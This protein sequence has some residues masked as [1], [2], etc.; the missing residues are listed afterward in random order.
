MTSHRSARRCFT[1]ASRSG[2]DSIDRISAV[3]RVSSCPRR[4][5]WVAWAR[6]I[7]RALHQKTDRDIRHIALDTSSRTSVTLIQVLC[8]HHF[9][10]T[11]SFV[12]H[13]P[14]LALMTTA[15]D[16]GLLIGDPA[17]DAT[18]MR[19][20]CGKIDLGEVWTEMTGLPFIYAAWTG[21]PA[22]IDDGV[23][24][25]L[26]QAQAEGRGKRSDRRGVRGG[27]CESRRAGRH[28]P[29]G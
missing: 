15:C 20:G 26:Q 5:H 24:R 25:A 8:R 2:A 10:I 11:P 28:L 19:S 4:R 1:R 9:H 27:R 3:G 17:F 14:D 16:A 18:T 12:P 7:G 22:G 23:I 21:R 6:C 13:G 29:K